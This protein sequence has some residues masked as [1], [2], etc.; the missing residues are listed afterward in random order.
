MN[1]FNNKPW[2]YRRKDKEPI[3]HT[4]SLDSVPCAV[5]AAVGVWLSWTLLGY[6]NRTQGTVG[7]QELL[8]A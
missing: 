6:G 7:A 2:E 3:S 4:A 5:L 8:T 1:G